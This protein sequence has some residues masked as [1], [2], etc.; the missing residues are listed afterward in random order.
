MCLFVVSFYYYIFLE[1]LIL[2]IYWDLM[3]VVVKIIISF[4]ENNLYRILCVS[5][6]IY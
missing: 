6:I 2:D 3:E 1:K 5:E 4:N